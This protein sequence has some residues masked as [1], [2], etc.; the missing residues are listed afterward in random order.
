MEQ[1][2]Y[3]RPRE[4]L[5]HSGVTA[6]TNAE[7][8][9]V[10]IGSGG[11]KT[12]VAKIARQ[13]NQLLN[14]LDATIDYASLTKISGMGM[15]HTLRIIAAIELGKRLASYNGSA[16][17]DI[18]I[19]R[20]QAS[21]KLSILY[22][23]LDGAGSVVSTVFEQLTTSQSSVVT[24]RKV[25][26]KV[27]ADTAWGLVVIIGSKHLHAKPDIYDLSLVADL[28]D[29]TKRLHIKLISVEYV[30]GTT[31]TYLYKASS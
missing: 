27:L 26:A 24:A 23:T 8:L 11:P 25:C 15:A 17:Q 6:L 3:E 19:T 30:A 18:D 31:K 14:R 5:Q 20:V 28:Q 4:K 1:L 21:R 7:L 12:P 29:L 10:I 9:Q 2:A 22:A 13:V 16:W